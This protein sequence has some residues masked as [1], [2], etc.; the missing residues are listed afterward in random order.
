MT[1]VIKLLEQWL[2]LL[3]GFSGVVVPVSQVISDDAA[4]DAE[5]VPDL[6]QQLQEILDFVVRQEHMWRGRRTKSPFAL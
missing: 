2:P 5:A 3:A 6:D 4:S 1:R